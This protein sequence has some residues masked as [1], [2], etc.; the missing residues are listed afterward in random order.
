MNINNLH[1]NPLIISFYK[2]ILS[3]QKYMKFCK[4]TNRNLFIGIKSLSVAHS[5]KQ[6]SKTINFLKKDMQK[7][8]ILQSETMIAFCKSGFVGH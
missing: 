4:N 1:K 2:V 6:L 3:L 5:K 7:D 8:V